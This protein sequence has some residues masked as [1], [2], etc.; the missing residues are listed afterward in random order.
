MSK[1]DHDVFPEIVSRDGEVLT[2]EFVAWSLSREGRRRDGK[3]YPNPVPLEPPIGYVDHVPLHEQIAAMVRLQLS[4]DSEEV[5]TEDEANDFDVADDY[6]PSS[7]WEL[8]FE[9]TVPWAEA[10]RQIVSEA[11]KIGEPPLAASAAPGASGGG[12]GGDQPP[13]VSEPPKAS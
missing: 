5:E 7:P 11:E 6:D 4:A 12:A 2:P 10:V 13:R 9:P 8:N 3:E 1:K